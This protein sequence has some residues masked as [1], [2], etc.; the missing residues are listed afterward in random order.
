MTP[1]PPQNSPDE[2]RPNETHTINWQP[3][4][5]SL[6]PYITAALIIIVLSVLALAGLLFWLRPYVTIIQSPAGQ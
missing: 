5:N 4:R 6:R 3:R 2:M 1:P